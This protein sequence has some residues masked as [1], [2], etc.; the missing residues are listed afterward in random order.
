[1]KITIERVDTTTG[2][3]EHEI[4]ANVRSDKEIEEKLITYQ[5]RYCNRH[6]RP[7]VCFKPTAKG[8]IYTATSRSTRIHRCETKS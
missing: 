7:L 6:E 5:S 3:V 4:Q 1:M 8:M 2:I